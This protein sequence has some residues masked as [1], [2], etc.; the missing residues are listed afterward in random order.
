MTSHSRR[1]PLSPVT[2]ILAALFGPADRHCGSVILFRAL[3][4]TLFIVGLHATFSLG[5]SPILL[6]ATSW[7][8]VSLATHAAHSR[9]RTQGA[10]ILLAA[11]WCLYFI[12]TW[13]L[14]YGIGTTPGRFFTV[15]NFDFHSSLALIFLTI[16]ATTTWFF[17]RVRSAV[18]VEA[19]VLAGVCILIFAGHRGFH[20]NRPKIVNTLAW[21]LRVDH[22]T[23]LLIIGAVLLTL[24][25]L[26]VAFAARA[27]RP[28]AGEGET[29]R[30]SSGS[31]LPVAS[32]LLAALLGVVVAVQYQLY[33]YFSSTMVARVSNGVGM[34][35]SPG[36]SPLTFQSALGSTNQPSALVR[37]EGD[38]ANNPYTPMLYLREN[39]LSAFTGQEMVNAGRAYD[40]DVPNINVNDSY[41]GK[42]DADLFQRTPVVHSV[43]P[44][45][46]HKTVFAV[47]YPLSIVQLKNPKPN[48]FKASYRAYSVAPGFKQEEIEG[49]AVGDPRWS[50]EVRRH[51]LVPHPD[52][53]YKELAEKVTSEAITPVQKIYALTAHLNKTAIYTLSPNHEVKTNEDQVA[54]FLFGDHRGYC[55]HFAHAIVFMARSLGIPAR[56]GTG[57]LTD[58]SQSK[59]GH[60]LLLMSD[61]HAWPEIYVQNYGWLPFDVQPEQVESHADNKVDAKLLEEL[62]GMIDP[63]EELL[64]DDVAKNEP[65]MEEIKNFQLP[66]L[67]SLLST[68][69]ALTAL[70]G[71]LKGWLIFGWRLSR[72]PK[73]RASQA[74]ISAAACF[75]DIGC[76]REY[77][78]TRTEFSKRIPGGSLDLLT[79]ILL[80]RSYGKQTTDTIQVQEVNEA[81]L[82]VARNLKAL[83]WW[84]RTLGALNPA[85]VLT[86]LSGGRW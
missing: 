53:R 34:E 16:A 12:T 46:D 63:G 27:I 78:E 52:I 82:P 2:W 39:A 18:T 32:L 35:S 45:A 4:A 81:Y 19:I 86:W 1:S 70:F 55:V 21:E 83:P 22:L 10:L 51:Y 14:A 37:L 74:Y 56:I 3:W 66:S 71:F 50:E 61:R 8:G 75:E 28:L 62:M 44:L 15:N 38:Y 6:A 67:A 13:G 60:I 17:W 85:S 41:T 68:V 73:S 59:D 23:M 49:A 5:T 80:R 57:Y 9:L 40:S 11:S 48:R 33:S 20:F 24:S 25:A 26:Y 65:G 30:A 76:R 31:N 58:L 77:G 79:S 29:I 7:L 64:P 84:K 47:D 36:V 72:D 54:P 69:A 43:Y 42:E